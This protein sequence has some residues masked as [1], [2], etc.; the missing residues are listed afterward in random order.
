[1]KKNSF[2]T[3]LVFFT[4]LYIMVSCTSNNTQLVKLQQIDSLMEK[5]P[6]A[7]YDSLLHNQREM[8]PTG[9]RKVTMLFK[10]LKAKAEN[11]LYLQ[12]PTDS[13]FQEV[14]DYYDNKG[15]SNEKMEAHYLMGCIYRDQ[16]EAPKAMFWYNKAIEYADT[17][18]KDCDY[19]TLYSIYGQMADIY[20]KQYLHQEAI[21]AYL[22]YSHY[23]AYANDKENYILGL[24]N[25]ISEYYALGDTL[26]AITLTKKY[27]ALN[28]K[29]GLTQNA[30]LTLP[31]LIY[32]L[33]SQ[34]KYQQAYHYMKFFETQSGIYGKDGNILPGY[35][36]YYRAK[37]VYIV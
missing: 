4:L 28:M 30:A 7:A 25:T 23:A 33:L 21:K 32:T 18:S 20:S 13:T 26:K 19:I 14:V 16:K 17:L 15:N 29:Y 10:L 12:M 11:K 31:I 22:S 35:E 8:L 6:Q 9:G 34:E 1:M 37:G 5:N 2:M 3:L 27:Y 24:S 36:H